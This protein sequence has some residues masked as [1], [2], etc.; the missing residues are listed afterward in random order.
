MSNK[1]IITKDNRTL[2]ELLNQLPVE[3]D[4][5]RLQ[6]WRESDISWDVAYNTDGNSLKPQV[7]EQ[8]RTLTEAVKRI[9]DTLNSRKD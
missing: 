3:Y 6:I 1:S 4:G 9:I 7:W 2:D 5:V 8:G